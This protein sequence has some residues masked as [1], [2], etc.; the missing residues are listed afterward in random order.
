MAGAWI[1]SDIENLVRMPPVMF[2]TNYQG[3][4]H[5]DNTQI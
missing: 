4:S 5:A 3:G 1:H 2:Q